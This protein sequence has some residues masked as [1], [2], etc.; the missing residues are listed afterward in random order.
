MTIMPA[1]FRPTEQYPDVYDEVQQI[2]DSTNGFA[3]DVRT[4]DFE[5]LPRGEHEQSNQDFGSDQ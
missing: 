4:K 1:K 2:L 3:S 5:A